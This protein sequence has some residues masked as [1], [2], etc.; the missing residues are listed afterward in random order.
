MWSARLLFE[1]VNHHSEY[2]LPHSAWTFLEEPSQGRKRLGD[3][4]GAKLGNGSKY[5]GRNPTSSKQ[6]RSKHG[7]MRWAISCS[8]PELGSFQDVW[9]LWDIEDTCEWWVYHTHE[10]L[11]T[12]ARAS[13]MCVETHVVLQTT[14]ALHVSLTT[15]QLP[16]TSLGGKAAIFHK[17]KRRLFSCQL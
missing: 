11:A 9:K 4:T 14:E 17:L 15:E 8:L 16:S 5:Q 7:R 3:R 6:M 10:D 13:V 12:N 2:T 1:Q